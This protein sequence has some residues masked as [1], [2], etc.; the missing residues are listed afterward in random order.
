VKQV[1]IS[2][3]ISILKFYCFI[4]FRHPNKRRK[5]E[6]VVE[7]MNRHSDR[8]R[9]RVL[10]ELF[11]KGS[12]DQRSLPELTGV[13]ETGACIGLKKLEEEGC[14]YTRRVFNYGSRKNEA[15]YYNKAF[16]L[17]FPPTGSLRWVKVR[18]ITD[19]GKERVY[20]LETTT[21][22]FVANGI[23]THNCLLGAQ[24]LPELAQN[25]AFCQGYVKTY[26]FQWDPKYGFTKP[27]NDPVVRLFFLPF[28]RA[29]IGLLNGMTNREAHDLEY[30]E[31][32]TNAERTGDPE[33][34]DLLIRE[35][36]I[37]EVFG[38]PNAKL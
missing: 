22:D 9:R 18:R 24:L 26:S 34:R 30:S 19:A 17:I 25:G 3:E 15:V 33:I 36:N 28:M 23:L 4:G 12:I 38:D 5:L 1:A 11:D 21:G 27:E 29:T 37:F 16:P 35:A 14:V 10:L 32:M 8:K 6:E 2:D 13:S 31:Y 20:D 7:N